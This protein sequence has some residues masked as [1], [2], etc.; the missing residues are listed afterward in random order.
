MMASLAITLLGW[1]RGATTTTTSEST[2]LAMQ[3][4]PSTVNPHELDNH[5]SGVH[6][7][8]LLIFMGMALVLGLMLGMICGWELQKYKRDVVDANVTAGAAGAARAAEDSVLLAIA[9]AER[10]V[11]ERAKAHAAAAEWW[12]RAL[13]NTPSEGTAEATPALDE[14]RAAW[15]SH[16]ASSAEQPGAPT[17]PTRTF[18]TTRTGKRFHLRRNC[19]GLKPS[20]G[21]FEADERPADLKPCILC[22]R[23]CFRP[24]TGA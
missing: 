24:G 12:A 4:G 5:G 16:L 20:M 7:L 15:R 17:P 14:A 2:C 6:W 18:F 3:A 1:C 13:R 11:E 9:T 22:A 21:I 19:T 10:Q 8:S 23:A